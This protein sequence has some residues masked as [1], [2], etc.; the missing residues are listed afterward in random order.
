M[1]VFIGLILYCIIT[2][3]LLLIAISV[4]LV[5]SYLI[6]VRPSNVPL[7]VMGHE[8]TT[9]QQ[10]SIAA[11]ISFPLFFIAGTGSAVFWVLGVSFFL[12]GLH[13]SFHSSIEEMGGEDQTP[14]V[15]TV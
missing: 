1:F 13:A 9:N 7:K 12:I 8:V 15:E 11:L 5:M 2:S 6:S 4:F 3:P 14:F 10:Y